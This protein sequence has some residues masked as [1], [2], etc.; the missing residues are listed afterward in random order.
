MQIL[1]QHPRGLRIAAPLGKADHLEQAHLAVEPDGEHIA[2][3]DVV[4]GR[5]LAH[6]IDADV[7]R[8]DESGSTGAGFDDPRV[9][10]PFI[11]ALAVRV[12]SPSD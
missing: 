12:I 11:E 10:Q 9:P 7:P 6:A 3:S 2:A 1:K 5:G 4:A 8:L